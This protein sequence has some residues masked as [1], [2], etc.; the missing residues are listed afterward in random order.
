MLSLGDELREDT[1]RR[2]GAI[3]SDFRDDIRVRFAYRIGSAG[4]ASLGPATGVRLAVY[5]DHRTDTGDAARAVCAIV[6]RHRGVE[7]VEVMVLNALE[8]EEAGRLIADGTVLFERDAAARRDFEVLAASSYEDFQLAEQVFLRERAERP[9][10]D[11]LGRTLSV[12]DMQIERLRTCAGTTADECRA[13]WRQAYVIERAFQLAVESCIAAARHVVAERG[14]RVPASAADAFA[15]LRDEGLLGAELAAGF[16]GLCRLRNR[17]VHESDRVNV[18]EVVGALRT[19]LDELARARAAL[20]AGGSGSP[21]QDDRQRGI[22][23]GAPAR[24]PAST[25]P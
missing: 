4:T 13:D 22:Q 21:H 12:L 2:L 15:A 9:F 19:G 3:V 18:G 24:R 14:L 7:R 1:A 23:G 10:G 25:P 20:G 11:T 5:V 17:L 6:A 16:G 8:F